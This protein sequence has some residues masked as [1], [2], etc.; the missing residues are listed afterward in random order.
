MEPNMKNSSWKITTYDDGRPAA[1]AEGLSHEQ[2]VAAIREAMYGSDPLTG[3]ASFGRALTA[4]RAQHESR[5]D[6]HR[7][8]VAA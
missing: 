6:E 3:G 8:P 4:A 1:T 2:A 5:T 7:V